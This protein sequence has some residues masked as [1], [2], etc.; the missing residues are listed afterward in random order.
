MDGK[1]LV[2]IPTFN[3]REN[4]REITEKII[5]LYSSLNILIVDDASR[6]GTGDVA[7]QLSLEFSNVSVMHRL[8]K[9][10]RG[11]AVKAG[12]EY[13]LKNYFDFVVE[14][15]ADGSHSPACPALRGGGTGAGPNRRARATSPAAGRGAGTRS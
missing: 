4:L 8:G 14:L 6:D 13:A 12:L 2:V 15:D 5:S 10:G 9:R 3:E 11:A 7:D 1:T